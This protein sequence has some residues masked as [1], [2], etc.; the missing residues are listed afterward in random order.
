MKKAVYLL[1]LLLISCKVKNVNSPVSYQFFVGTYTNGDSEGIYK[2]SISNEGKLSFVGLQAKTNNPSFLAK[3]IDNKTLLA[4][5]ETE[6]DGTGFVKSYKITKDTLLYKSKSKSGGAHPCFVSVKNNQVLVA[7]YSGGSIGYLKIDDKNGLTYL[8][9][10]QQHFG[11]GTTERQQKPHAHSAWFHPKTNEIIAVDLGTNELWFSSID[12]QDN[13]IFSEIQ[14]KLKMQDGA[15][16]RHLTFHPNNNWIYVL[17]ELDN[18]V[19]LIKKEGNMYVVSS[20][21][22]TLPKS[23]TKLSNG[24]DIHISKDGKFLYASNRGHDSIVI[25]KANSQDGLLELVGFETVKG[26]NPRNFSLTPDDNFLVVANQDTNNL[27]SFKRDLKTGKLIFID[28]IKAANPVCV[29]F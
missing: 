7:N 11:K 20:S 5:D 4:V 2:Y 15:G 26:K 16:P 3:T 25:Y 29:L 17:N 19:S 13:F 10:L 28:E 8:L 18:T 27:I 23:F 1:L 9:D 22:S 12:K 14:Q 21:I 24:A 6:E